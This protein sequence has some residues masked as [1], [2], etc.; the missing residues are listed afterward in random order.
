MVDECFCLPTRQCE[1]ILQ[2][3]HRYAYLIS[4]SFFPLFSEFCTHVWLYPFSCL[5]PQANQPGDVS[6]GGP[7]VTEIRLGDLF[8]SPHRILGYKPTCWA[9]RRCQSILAGLGSIPCVGSWDSGRR[10]TLRVLGGRPVLQN[11]SCENSQGEFAQVLFWRIAV[12]LFVI[13]EIRWRFP[14]GIP[15]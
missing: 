10:L 11:N 14:S 4:P 6:T 2:G 13:T 8:G 1:W 5:Q 12:F 7:P 3:R 9:V 15:A